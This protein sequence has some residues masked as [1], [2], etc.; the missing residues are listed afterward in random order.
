[1]AQKFLRI[2]PKQAVDKTSLVSQ[3]VGYH[4]HTSNLGQDPGGISRN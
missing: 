3:T 1:M 4:D 2:L